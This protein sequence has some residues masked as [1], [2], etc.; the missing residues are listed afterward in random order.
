MPPRS[1]TGRMED[2]T[3]R[4]RRAFD[5]FNASGEPV[6]YEEPADALRAVGLEAG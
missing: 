3:D 5:A 4:L 6:V 2:R 1:D